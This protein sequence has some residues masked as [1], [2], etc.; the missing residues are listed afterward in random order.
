M[1]P[2]GWL[3][4]IWIGVILL[5]AVGGYFLWRWLKKASVVPAAPPI[6]P[7]VRARRKLEEA[8]GLIAEAKPFSTMVSDT[9]RVYLEER[10]D[11]RAPERTTE[12]FL[13]ELQATELL[14]PDQK[15][16]LSD[17]LSSC[18]L[19]KFAKYEPTEVELRGLHDSALRLVNETEPSPIAPA[20]GSTQSSTPAPQPALQ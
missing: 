13:Y 3:L 5:M 12:E 14:T 18:D 7:H 17:F 19:V 1:I 11:F 6:P 15:Q 16:S 9:L 8:L 2:N 4:V 10:F 20:I